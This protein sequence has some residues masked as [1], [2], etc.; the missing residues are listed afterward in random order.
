MRLV[1]FFDVL[2]I[3][4]NGEND[5]A[6]LIWTFIFMKAAFQDWKIPLTQSRKQLGR[7]LDTMRLTFDT[8][9]EASSCMRNFALGQPSV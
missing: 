9:G 5:N 3:T 2:N 6:S 8:K 7:P 1:D 4:Y